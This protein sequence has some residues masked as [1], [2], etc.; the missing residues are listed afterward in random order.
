MSFDPLV[1][2]GRAPRRL[3][4][5]GGLT[6]L[7]NGVVFYQGAV[8][9]MDEAALAGLM[10]GDV[11]PFGVETLV[12]EPDRVKRTSQAQNVTPPPPP[13]PPPPPVAAWN[14]ADADAFSTFSN[15]NLTI[16]FPGGGQ[17]SVRG[18][19]SK[20]SGKWYYEFT[21]NAGGCGFA[22]ASHDLSLYAGGTTNSVGWFARGLGWSAYNGG[23][24]DFNAQVADGTIC[25]LAIDIDAGKFWKRTAGVW[26]GDPA[27]G[28]GG[29]A[30]AA[31]CAAGPIFPLYCTYNTAGTL[32][33]NFGGSAFAGSV[34][35]GF[36][37][38]A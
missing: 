27:A 30:I 33:V 29:Y 37:A 18:T 1:W 7:A 23:W 12:G 31:L 34:P 16:T 38:W 5:S 21:V 35:G 28:T 4:A 19:T 6:Q 26:D 11:D 24:L 2:D 8:R 9:R 20:T 3:S 17:G 15:A 32:T 10:L 22:N 25:A 13:P 14:P 36:A